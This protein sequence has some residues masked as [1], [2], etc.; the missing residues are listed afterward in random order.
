MEELDAISQGPKPFEPPTAISLA[1]LREA[2][3]YSPQHIN[4]ITTALHK[5]LPKLWPAHVSDKDFYSLYIQ[6]VEG[7]NF[8]EMLVALE[9]V[10][11]RRKSWTD[12]VVSPR[13]IGYH[14][15]DVLRN[16]A[17]VTAAE[18]E[19]LS[20]F[21]DAFVLLDRL[22]K[23]AHRRAYDWV[24]D[25]VDREFE[26]EGTDW[27]DAPAS[28]SDSLEESWNEQV[29]ALDV[30]VS[31]LLDSYFDEETL[32][33]VQ[34]RVDALRALVQRY[35]EDLDARQ[36]SELIQRTRSV[37]DRLQGCLAN[38]QRLNQAI[39]QSLHELRAALDGRIEEVRETW[40]EEVDGLL[41]ALSETTSKL[42]DVE[43][44]IVRAH[45]DDDDD[46]LASGYGNR[47]MAREARTSAVDQLAE[48]AMRWRVGEEAT[49]GGDETSSLATEEQEAHTAQ[50]REKQRPARA[51]A[52]S[53]SVIP[54]SSSADVPPALAPVPDPDT[55]SGAEP[56]GRSGADRS[57]VGAVPEQETSS[58]RV[59]PSS[60]PAPR[61]SGATVTMD[62]EEFLK[63]HWQA[64]DG[65]CAPAPWLEDGFQGRLREFA[66][67]L[68]QPQTL[69]VPYLA[70]R[71]AQQL[72]GTPLI[73]PVD[74]VGLVRLMERQQPDVP[75][76]GRLSRVR[77]SLS[78]PEGR[79][80][81]LIAVL[82][83]ILRP[84]DAV[85]LPDDVGLIEENLH[86]RSEALRG[87]INGCAD[88]RKVGVDAWGELGKQLRSRGPHTVGEWE[89]A[90]MEAREEF[91]AELTRLR[92][93]VGGKVQRTH[94]RK[95]WH[96]FIDGFVDSLAAT[97][98]PT[99]SPEDHGRWNLS[100]LERQAR[101]LPDKHSQIA[102]R[103]GARYVDRDKMDRAAADLSTLALK[104]I[105]A[106]RGLRQ[107]SA[108]KARHS[109]PL[110]LAE[111]Q[112]LIN[113]PALPDP[114]E[115]LCRVA[116]RIEVKAEAPR[117]AGSL[118]C[119]T[120]EDLWQHPDLLPLVFG[121]EGSQV[122]W[123]E[124][125]PADEIHQPVRAMA[126]LIQAQE[127][128][129]ESVPENVPAQLR[130]CLLA[131]HRQ[132]LLLYLVGS[133]GLD[134]SEAAH[135]HSE[136]V[137]GAEELTREIEALKGYLR[138]AD[139]LAL[140][141][142]FAFKEAV[143]QASRLLNERTR[144]SLEMPIIREWIARL[145]AHMAT[146][147]DEGVAS[148]RAEAARLQDEVQ[149]QRVEQALTAGRYAIALRCLQEPDARA[150]D[151]R[152]NSRVTTWRLEAI[153]RYPS[154][155][156]HLQ[157]IRPGESGGAFA[158][159][160]SKRDLR[161]HDHTRALRR[162]FYDLISGED[163]SQGS[164]VEGLRE[165]RNTYITINC[166]ALL[167][168]FQQEGL[169]PTFVPQLLE[170]H[171]LTI[172]TPDKAIAPAR[173]VQELPRQATARGR[174]EGVTVFLIPGIT[175]ENRNRVLEE[176]RRRKLHLALVDDVDA[177][178]LLEATTG[179]QNGFLAFVEI[180]LEQLH[181][182][183]Q[184]S[185]FDPRDGQYV[186]IETYVGR[187]DLAK[188]L[189]QRARYTR[190]FS[191][192]KLGKSALLKYC[193]RTYDGSVLPSGNTLR[194]LFIVATG[195]DSERWTSRAILEELRAR[196]GFVPTEEGEEDPGQWLMSNLTRYLELNPKVSLLVILDE[197]DLF[198]E[199][200]I[201]QYD[202]SRERCL[203]FRMTK[204]TP[205]GLD[206]RQLP[207]VR[208]VFSGYRVTDTR[209]AAFANAGDVLRLAPLSEEDATQL[210]EAPL[211]RMGI[212]AREV[213]PSAARL[214]GFQPA[215]LIRFGNT[216]LQQLQLRLSAAQRD[217]VV[218]TDE[219]VSN[220]YHQGQVRD[221]IRTVV[222]NNFQGNR[223]G[224]IVLWTLL[225]V[226]NGQLPGRG[227]PDA[228]EVVLARIRT[229]DSNTDWLRELDPTETG[230]IRRQLM[231]FANRHLLVE[232]RDGGHTTYRLKFPNH[233]PVLLTEGDPE[234]Q[235]RQD[236]ERVR[237][238]GQNAMLIRS[239][240]PTNNM[241]E[242]RFALEE[243]KRELGVRLVVAGSH[244]VEPLQDD[245]GG[246]PDRL[247]YTPADVID[248]AQV[249]QGVEADPL[250]VLN[251]TPA[252][253][254][255]LA[256]RRDRDKSVPLLIGGVD[257]L[258]WA[259]AQSAIVDGVTLVQVGMN[260]VSEG[261]IS[262]W[263]ERLRGL[264]FER[265]DGLG[266]IAQTTSGIPLLL[267]I[268]DEALGGGHGGD[269]D[270]AKLGAI[271][272]GFDEALGGRA[273]ALVNGPG[274]V[275]L[276]PREIELMR[277]VV[278]VARNS[279]G[280]FDLQEELR[281]AWDEL[282]RAEAM[283]AAAAAYTEP[284]DAVALD[285]LKLSGLVPIGPDGMV[286]L[287]PKDALFRLVDAI[288]TLDA[289]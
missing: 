111:A 218:V 86:I 92:H 68:V 117:A 262:W 27:G 128:P 105:E 65:K 133:G 235:I 189:A 174:L 169:N 70:S 192:R 43:N 254:G 208:F 247:G 93:S 48:Q 57:P 71:A 94:C 64:P 232:S 175:L 23:T 261:R 120:E 144:L 279:S 220:T 242:I 131:A 188:D 107:A 272:A 103:G 190:V 38:E 259:L 184:L 284:D 110:P 112:A 134:P 91:A 214:C 245:R 255:L 221:E 40:A 130:E 253:A 136:E 171:Q 185:P 187:S 85:F 215:V 3:A 4:V 143:D 67:P 97:L 140:P 52:D 26:P 99:A 90:L 80:A 44:T 157:S 53:Q 158:D 166:S 100:D 122:A 32:V 249:A 170:L 173:Y 1:D 89:N 263:F 96:E 164:P 141:N 121:D 151:D 31:G 234:N 95:A 13:R 172:A 168:L 200:Q 182:G 153:D 34:R 15:Y 155:L 139:Q 75:D 256:E 146:G 147:C 54:D 22:G 274:A 152:E 132:D 138:K 203:S 163:T 109:M 59:A 257:L 49:G 186:A 216:L 267:G 29:E 124:T 222:D 177:C 36:R 150:S 248:N 114:V 280:S 225:D 183:A 88:A 191:G 239:I 24:M 281:D 74:L 145:G 11:K 116:I 101:R 61:A 209:E 72:E 230:E 33:E 41:A 237:G 206:A 196:C 193:E 180:I 197:A 251:A 179:R 78:G 42:Q 231:D 246:L 10:R 275:R 270:A 268:W 56:A 286:A 113:G 17:R 82:L 176:A 204:E 135:I 282:Y 63:E 198:V 125:I 81:A 243:G 250:L 20:N 46:A 167:S 9:E 226:F 289:S 16:D 269:V 8:R 217:G 252:T 115:E 76:Q 119:L 83:E 50:L 160:W 12:I 21:E 264:H 51:P 129:E 266:Q 201:R 6:M 205:G 229:I 142:A 35:G 228:H 58:A 265:G 288:E 69:A 165:I 283:P 159:A 276:T 210:I 37:A 211:A 207:R 285:V 277:M 5:A 19:E 271:G 202:E 14:A 73:D 118:L 181:I 106:A 213:A 2:L 154:P 212:D 127:H 199:N 241:D 224:R 30:A 28:G 194:V 18:L 238:S 123:R 39:A 178:R 223:T 104:V 98:L 219:D 47:K 45:D 161:E 25:T 244:W 278:A 87:F 233:L 137:R 79:D 156:A 258:R 62:Y 7:G 227:L 287:E 77:Q 162:A 273:R 240:L 102:D 195:G 126:V 66:R 148:I 60:E 108:Q 260:R 55:V 149:R 84:S 236:I